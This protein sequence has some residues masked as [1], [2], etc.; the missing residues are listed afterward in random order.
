MDNDGIKGMRGQDNKALGRWLKLGLDRL[1]YRYAD[2]NYQQHRDGTVTVQSHVDAIALGGKVSTRNAYLIYP[3]DKVR[4]EHTFILP[5][6]MADLPRLGVRWTLPA[7]FE[8]FEWYGLGPHETYCDRK[9][10]D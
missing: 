3:D 9:P 8:Q 10:L 4:I 1:D 5:A 6:N 2:I 7:D